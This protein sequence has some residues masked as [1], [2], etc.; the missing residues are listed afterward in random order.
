M[1][2]RPISVGV[3]Q[4]KSGYSN[5]EMQLMQWKIWSINGIFGSVAIEEFGQ[6][7]LLLPFLLLPFLHF[8][9]TLRWWQDRF[10]LIFSASRTQ[11][12]ISIFS[13]IRNTL[14]KQEAE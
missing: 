3:Q 11:V 2:I 6:C 9:F 10:L 13:Q 12:L 1:K 8:V 7:V 4:I 5:T 14:T